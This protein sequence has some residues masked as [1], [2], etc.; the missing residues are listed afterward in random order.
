[1]NNCNT[2]IGKRTLRARILEPM[3]DIEEIKS[4]QSCIEELIDKDVQI[5][6]ALH[7]LLHLFNGVDRLSK[8]T[9]V[10]PQ[11]T[12]IRRAEVL[13]NRTVLLRKC[14]LAVPQL[15]AALVHFD[16]AEFRN[17]QEKLND[18][19]YAQILEHINQTVDNNIGNYGGDARSMQTQRIYCVKEG[20][21]DLVDLSR[22]LYR[23]L[24][25]EVKSEY[26]QG[27]WT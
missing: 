4:V 23:D 9:L 13:I 17:I 14:L 18:V 25:G 8:L 15:Q 22:G 19:R 12:N 21:S 16:N 24:I 11:E 5:I 10:V 20:V 1:M 3:C 2:Q 27:L 26:E 7:T 6:H